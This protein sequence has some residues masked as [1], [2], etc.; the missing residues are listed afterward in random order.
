V[1]DDGSGGAQPDGHGLMGI[2]D[3]IETLGGR[4]RIESTE[5]DGTVLA[6]QLPLSTR[7]PRESE[8]PLNATGF[9]TLDAW[10]ASRSRPLLK[11]LI[12]ASNGVLDHSRM[13]VSR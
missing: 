7:W 8:R 12:H 11:D 13:A 10:C 5:G 6:A 9:W 1:R 4:L 2:A 3:R